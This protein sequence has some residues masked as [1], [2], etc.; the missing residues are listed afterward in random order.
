MIICY[1]I[2]F[3][4]ALWNYNMEIWTPILALYTK[5][6]MVIVVDFNKNY[7]KREKKNKDDEALNSK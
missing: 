2:C 7:V 4:N 3:C 5:K 1:V 6:V